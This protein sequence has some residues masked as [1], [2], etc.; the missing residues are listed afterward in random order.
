MPPSRQGA[1]RAKSRSS[2]MWMWSRELRARRRGG[3]PRKNGSRGI[4]KASTSTKSCVGSLAAGG[5][6]KR[7]DSVDVSPARRSSFPALP[8]S[9]FRSVRHAASS[10]L[11]TIGRRHDDSGHPFIVRG[12]LRTG[13]GRH[14]ETVG[15]LRNGEMEKSRNGEIEKNSVRLLSLE[16]REASLFS[17]FRFLH[18]SIASPRP[19]RT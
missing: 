19:L 11:R 7:W 9:S 12:C 8:G 17:I 2:W 15:E 6:W 16:S 13:S 14:I 5:E 4:S 1:D 3:A 10:N 18:F